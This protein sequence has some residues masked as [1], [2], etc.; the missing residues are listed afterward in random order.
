MDFPKEKMELTSS[1]SDKESEKGWLVLNL[2]TLDL[3]GVSRIYINLD[4]VEELK[5]GAQRHAE[6]LE[7]MRTLL[8][9][10]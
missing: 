6:V 8:G 4:V 10:D 1:H 7:R 5:A 9:G 3:E 2:G